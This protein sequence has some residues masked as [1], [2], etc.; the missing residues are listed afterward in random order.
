[1][2]D[3]LLIA[4]VL[5]ILGCVIYYVVNI[6]GI[7]VWSSLMQIAPFTLLLLAAALPYAAYLALRRRRGDEPFAPGDHV[8]YVKPKY[9][10]HPG[11]RAERIEPAGKGDGYTYIV[12]K[13][14][15]VV[16]MIGDEKVEVVTNG[17]KHHVLNVDDPQLH[18]AGV[19]ESLIFRL[20]WQKQW[21]ALAEG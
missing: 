11:E 15:T 2:E 21:P 20:R 4:L 19:I 14:W 1:M 3:L 8:V 7:D 5:W 10:T 17:G 18:R 13:P 9:S 12:R 16:R 6:A